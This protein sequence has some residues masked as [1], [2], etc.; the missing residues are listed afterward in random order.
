MILMISMKILIL[1]LSTL[2]AVAQDADEE[3]DEVDYIQMKVDS[4]LSL[5]S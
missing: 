4:I 2:P 3:D 1:I 5:A